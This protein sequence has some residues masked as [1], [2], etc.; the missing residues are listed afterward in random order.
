[1]TACDGSPCTIRLTAAHARCPEDGE[2]LETL[3]AALDARLALARRSV[4][5]V[6]PFRPQNRVAG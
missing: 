1:M 6:L 2:E 3:L 5:T 4:G